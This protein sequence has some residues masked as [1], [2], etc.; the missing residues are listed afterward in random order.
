MQG[1]DCVVVGRGLQISVPY[2]FP[3]IMGSRMSVGVVQQKNTLRQ[4]ASTVLQIADLGSF[5][6]TSQ[7]L[8][9]FR[10]FPFLDNVQGQ[11][12]GNLRTL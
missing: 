12:L 1:V 7:T 4:S 2:G 9:L 10:W 5:R 11:D 6:N 3:I 8:H